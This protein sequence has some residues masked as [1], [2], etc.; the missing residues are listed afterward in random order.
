MV[1]QLYTQNDHLQRRCLSTIFAMAR[2][3][4]P[5]KISSPLVRGFTR[6]QLYIRPCTM[7]LWPTVLGMILGFLTFYPATLGTLGFFGCGDPLPSVRSVPTDP[8]GGIS[9]LGPHHDPATLVGAGQSTSRSCRPR[10][11]SNPCTGSGMVSSCWSTGSSS[12]R[13]GRNHS[14]TRGASHPNLY[15]QLESTYGQ[16]FR[17]C[18]IN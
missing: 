11:S 9:P 8:S 6:W 15:S 14:F 1:R 10:R 16:G 18:R 17:D 7:V 12:Q 5:G 3:N 2:I 13:N 4:N